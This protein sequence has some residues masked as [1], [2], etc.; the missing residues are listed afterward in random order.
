MASDFKTTISALWSELQ[1]QAPRFGAENEIVLTVDG[2]DLVFR[3]SPDERHLLV[4]AAAGQLSQD[5]PNRAR[6]VRTLMQASLGV[7]GATST[8]LNIRKELD[9]VNLTV[10]VQAVYSYDL[11]RVGDLVQLIQ[12]VLRVYEIPRGELVEASRPRRSLQPVEDA[13]ESVIFRP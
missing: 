7:L 5:P 3:E 9:G 2:V 8:S 6:Q 13:G 12:E 4:T 10:L 11:D 1:L